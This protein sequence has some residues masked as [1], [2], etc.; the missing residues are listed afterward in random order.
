M[1]EASGSSASKHVEERGG[2]RESK[3]AVSAFKPLGLNPP[4]VASSNQIVLVGRSPAHVF[5]AYHFVT[6]M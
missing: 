5:W 6:S 2:K 4:T 3:T 1:T